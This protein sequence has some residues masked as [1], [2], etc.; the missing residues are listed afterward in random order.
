MREIS[1]QSLVG[2]TS[3]LKDAVRNGIFFANPVSIYQWKANNS[4]ELSL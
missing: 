4:V 3:R 2:E 1:S